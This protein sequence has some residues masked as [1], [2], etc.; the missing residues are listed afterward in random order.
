MTAW[1]L[2]S[3]A[4]FRPSADAVF[5][6]ASSCSTETFSCSSCSFSI[7]V[8]VSMLESGLLA[9]KTIPKESVKVKTNMMVIGLRARLLTSIPFYFG[10]CF[11]GQRISGFLLGNKCPRCLVLE[12]RCVVW[13]NT[14]MLIILLVC[15]FVMYPLRQGGEVKNLAVK[16]L[17]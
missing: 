9:S 8:F 3:R 12:A 11:V 14:A 13:H 6:K 10:Y 15:Y 4:F 16:V 7:I 5:L 17:K 1:I 2:F